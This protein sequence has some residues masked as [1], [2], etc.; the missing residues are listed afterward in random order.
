MLPPTKKKKINPL[1]LK[2]IFISVAIHLLAGLIL[3]SITIYK[4]VVPSEAQFE[5]PPVVEQEEPPP[6]VKV[7]IRPQQPKQQQAQNLA[8]RPVANIAVANVDVNLPNMEQNFTVSTGL[9]GMGGG[10]LLGGTRGNIGMGLSDVS[11]FGLKSRAERILFVIDANRQMVTDKKGGL[12]SYKIIKDEITDMVG[13]LSAGTLFNVM[14]QDRTKM[15]LF[16]PQLVSAGSEVH[17][18]LIQWINPINASATNVGL[19]GNRLAKKP[20][21]KTLPDEEVHKILPH[22]WRGNETCFITQ[23]ALEQNV[24]AIFFI[25]GYHRGF[26]TVLAP[27]SERMVAEWQRK[28]AKRDYIEQ[29]AKHKAEIA[30]MQAR[31]KAEVT[32]IDAER[33]KKGQPPRVLSQRHGVYSNANELGL[34]WKTN[35]PG[36]GPGRQQVKDSDVSKYFRKLIDKLYEDHDKPVPSVNVVLFLAG[37]EVFSDAAKK[38]L[39]QYVRFF[40]GKNRVIRGEDEISSARSSKSTNN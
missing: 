23:V 12:N 20:Q 24:D 18:Q 38:Q 13:N 1:L 37:D 3:G 40:R 21:L 7:Q 35:H 10:S 19:E 34:K 29:L 9:G 11:V 5:E 16:K 39:D 26:E 15:M 6:P 28:I 4:Y 36:H 30:Q 27:A 25:T 14:L 8:M 17:Q 31:V 33:K 32:R 22:G 2:V